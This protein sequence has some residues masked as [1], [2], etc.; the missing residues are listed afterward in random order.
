[1]E[2]D[3]NNN[4]NLINNINN[5]VVVQRKLIRQGKINL[6][7]YNTDAIIKTII[8]LEESFNAIEVMPIHNFSYSTLEISMVISTKDQQQQQQ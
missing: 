4:N 8:N 6:R 3:N 2:N 7:N 5:N 1:M